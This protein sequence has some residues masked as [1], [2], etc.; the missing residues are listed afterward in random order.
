MDRGAFR[1]QC[2]G[3]KKNAF[4]INGVFNMTAYVSKTSKE[5]QE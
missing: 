3:D 5:R 1:G 4:D 2:P